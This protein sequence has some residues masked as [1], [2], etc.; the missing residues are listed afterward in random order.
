MRAP[1]PPAGSRRLVR[2]TVVLGDTRG[3]HPRFGRQEFGRVAG[4]PSQAGMP[5]LGSRHQRAAPPHPAAAAVDSFDGAC[6]RSHNR[7][8][9]PNRLEEWVADASAVL[10]RDPRVV[11]V[12]LEGSLA[13]GTYDMW[14]DADVH[15][16]VDDSAFDGI[17][18]PPESDPIV[19]AFGAVHAANRIPLGPNMV[20]VNATV[21]GPHRLDL[22]IERATTAASHPRL[23]PPR[24]LLDTGGLVPKLRVDPDAA[25]LPP[26]YQL[27]QL[28]NRYA[29]GFM[30][31]AR[32]AVR[33]LP[34]SMLANALIVVYEFLVPAILAQE[35]PTV[36][37]RELLHA[38][39]FLSP[40]RARRRC[41]AGP[42]AS[43]TRCRGLKQPRQKFAAISTG[44]SRS[45][46]EP[47]GV[48][49]NVVPALARPSYSAR[50]SI[51]EL[52]ADPDRVAGAAIRICGSSEPQSIG[53]FRAVFRVRRRPAFASARSLAA[54]PSL[55]TALGRTCRPSRYSGLSI[56]RGS[57]ATRIRLRLAVEPRR[58][59]RTER[60]LDR[61][62][63]RD[64][65]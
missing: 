10:E 43:S 23:A 42:P 25:V 65:G 4:R 58:R 28:V 33:G 5:V 54:S 40:P 22:Y 24:P 7:R 37:H 15:V 9:A 39:R 55:L 44:I 14:S 60:L 2:A 57:A 64:P 30:W 61:L 19:R 26:S 3:V 12:W 16:A 8:V 59:C 6:E 11:A 45:T 34:G 52:G 27:T 20:M 62:Y 21:T 17:A 13:D 36:M 53:T 1:E 32:L 18:V 41:R 29:Y 48:T 63:R 49:S 46:C 47:S 50:R 38:E 56:L 35:S 51:L 31:P